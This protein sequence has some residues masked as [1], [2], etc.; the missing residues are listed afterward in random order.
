MADGTWPSGRTETTG[1]YSTFGKGEVF[2]VSLRGL[3]RSFNSVFPGFTV[4]RGKGS[5]D[6]HTTTSVE[7]R[8]VPV[9]L[10]LVSRAL[11]LHPAKGQS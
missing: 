3:D 2:H 9:E 10:E 11:E 8:Q 5:N 7:L 6:F 1:K 4:T